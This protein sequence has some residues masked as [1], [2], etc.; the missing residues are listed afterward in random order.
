M[1]MSALQ[2][3]KRVFVP[4]IKKAD[5]NIMQAVEISSLKDASK[6]VFGIRQPD[7]NNE[8]RKAD[9]N[10]LD[11]IFVPAIVFDEAGFR[12]GYG[13][14]FYDRWLAAIDR[15]KILAIAYDFQVIQRVPREPFDISVALI[16]TEKRTRRID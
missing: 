6:S 4:T 15:N 9:K 2:S 3:G 10:E 13:R 11:L 16:V 8:S 7:L 14:G 1:I 12:I 5:E